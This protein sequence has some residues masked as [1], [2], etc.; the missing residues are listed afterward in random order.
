MPIEEPLRTWFRRLLLGTLVEVVQA[1]GVPVS[2]SSVTID[3]HGD[4]AFEVPRLNNYMRF[5]GQV[6]GTVDGEIPA[7]GMAH[8]EAQLRRVRPDLLGVVIL[9]IGDRLTSTGNDTS[10]T[11]SGGRLTIRFDLVAD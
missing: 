2:L 10:A 11:V 6:L 3:F 7:G 5:K 8:L 1:A 9:P 4:S